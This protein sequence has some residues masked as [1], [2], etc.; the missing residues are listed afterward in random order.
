MSSLP[1]PVSPRM[2]TAGG[3][4]GFDL[5]EDPAQGGAVPD[6]LPEVVPG[7]DLLL[8]VGIL[9]GELVLERLNLPE[10]RLDLLEGQGVLHGHGHLVGDQLQ[11]THVRL[12]V[13]G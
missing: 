13:G 12:A 3:G 1:V 5:L 7:A 10:V 11:K 8:Q 4:D 2:S 9:L 6:D